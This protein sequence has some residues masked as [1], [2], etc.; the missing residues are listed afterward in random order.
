M[1]LFGGAASLFDLTGRTAVVTGA[2]RGIGLAI[3]TALGEAGATVVISSETEADC[4]AVAASLK[5]QGVAALPIAC[6]VSNSQAI[7]A[8][9]ADATAR[10]GG[11]DILVCNAGVEG[12]VGPIA[13]AAP[14]AID[15]VLAINLKSAITLTSAASPHMASKGGGSV[16]LIASIAGLRGNKAIG[17]YGLTKAALAQ[18]AR[19]LAVEW[20]PSAVR[21]NAIAPGLIETDFSRGIMNNTAY[22]ERRLGLTPLRRMGRP[23]E[24]AAAALFLA[25]DGG[26]FVTGQ[27][28]VVDG[29]TV[30]SDGN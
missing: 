21:V 9:V 5:S 23:Q 14:E 3:A 20:G 30:I 27:T 1:S 18:L 13:D 10:C 15:A 16:I 19:N 29:G 26:G 6:D 22:L 11:L 8:L 12:P 7:K 2:T 24:I 25:G 17:V 4:Q 28:L